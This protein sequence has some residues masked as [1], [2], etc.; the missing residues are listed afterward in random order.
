MKIHIA[1]WLPDN[2]GN[3]SYELNIDLWDLHVNYLSNV[4]FYNAGLDS[5]INN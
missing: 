1:Y 2:Q 4:Y 3:W 5:N